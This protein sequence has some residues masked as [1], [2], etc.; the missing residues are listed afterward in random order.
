[1]ETSAADGRARELS[2]PG[3]PDTGRAGG[4]FQD[5]AWPSPVS[6]RSHRAVLAETE[7]TL[8]RPAGSVRASRTRHAEPSGS[9]RGPVLT[10]VNRR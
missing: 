10:W 7:A 8:R 4:S 9:P 6:T 5:L 3:A 2:E 1:M